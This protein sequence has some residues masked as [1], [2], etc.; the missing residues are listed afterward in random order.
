M[1]LTLDL[2]LPPSVNHCYFTTKSGN[3]ILTAKAKKY[4]SLVQILAREFV[5]DQGWQLNAGNKLIA[6]MWWHWPDGR[7]RDVHNYT[8]VLFD[9]MEGIVYVDDK[10][11]LPRHQDYTV[12]K[13]EPGVRMHIREV[14]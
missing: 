6:D 9:A 13:L 1:E 3:R 11:V 2:P 14:I 8:K 4:I 7:R 5:K 10:Y 12:D